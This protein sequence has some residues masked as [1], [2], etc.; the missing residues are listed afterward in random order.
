LAA[1]NIP[2]AEVTSIAHGDYRVGNLMFHPSE[3]RV[4][5]ILN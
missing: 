1:Q 2:A 4:V 3:P 5:D